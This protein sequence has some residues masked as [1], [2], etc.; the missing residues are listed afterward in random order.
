MAP[1]GFIS[2]KLKKLQEPESQVCH[3]A[4]L[5]LPSF[6]NSALYTDRRRDFTHADLVHANFSQTKKH[7]QAKDPTYQDFPV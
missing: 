6:Y 4:Q 7:T 3:S 2:Q 1:H 5:M